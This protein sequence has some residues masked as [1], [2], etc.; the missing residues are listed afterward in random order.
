MIR[1][2]ASL[3]PARVEVAALCAAALLIAI[4]TGQ[5]D[6]AAAPNSATALL[7]PAEAQ[8]LVSATEGNA[9][10]DYRAV[11]Q[12]AEM[13]N[14]AMPFSRG[15]L[16]TARPFAP[17]GGLDDARAHLCLTQAIYYEA[18]FEPVVG[19][20]AVAQ[21]VL[22][23]V[24]HPA[25]AASVCGVVYEGA[26]KPVCQF[27][28]TCDGSLDRRPAAAAWAEA[29]RI[30]REALDG[31]V[32]PSVGTATHYH[33]DYVAPRWAPMLAKVE[34]IGT[35]I[36]YRWPG[37]WGRRPAFVQG[38]HGEPLGADALRPVHYLGKRMTRPEE[39]EASPAPVPEGPR[40]ARADND[41][42]GLLDT[43]KGWT[44]DIPA[45]EDSGHAAQAIARLQ[46]AP[47]QSPADRPAATIS[48]GAR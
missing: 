9:L 39:N 30:A 2:L 26:K 40:I 37:N 17:R 32:E 45:P 20:R 48:Q 41:V 47:S 11:G 5:P 46:A 1:R 42:G 36:F 8:A 43:S 22:N 28:F 7:A 21:V 34:K 25:F 18:G 13:I 44:L 24:R 12:S 31:R 33:A 16:D 15:G 23:R 35:H 6:E 19:R 27:S 38:Y 14:A 10:A 4:S 3:R 29:R